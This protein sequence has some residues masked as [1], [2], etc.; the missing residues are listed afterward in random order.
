VDSGFFVF[1]M[2]RNTLTAK[3]LKFCEHWAVHRNG[4]AAAEYAG[5]PKKSAAVMGSRWLNQ[6]KVLGRIDQL[7]EAA[8]LA[9]GGTEKD[10]LQAVAES[11]LADHTQAFNADGNP[12]PLREVPRHLRRQIRKIVRRKVKGK[13]RVADYE[14]IDQQESRR[15]L[16]MNKKLWNDKAGMDGTQPITVNVVT[17]LDGVPG[18]SIPKIPASTPS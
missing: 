11:A 12:K 4:T 1:C 3:Q 15:L 16:G 18:D 8:L 13:W 7:I 5:V 17:G 10:L 6:V 14:F 9:A 2:P